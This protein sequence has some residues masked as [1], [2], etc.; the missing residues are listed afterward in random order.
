MFG[1]IPERD[2]YMPVSISDSL[3]L[4]WESSANGSFPASSVSIYDQFVFVNDLSGR[5]HCF[6]IEDGKQVGV[7]KFKGAVYSTPIPFQRIVVF[8]VAL[9]KENLTELVFY[10]F[11]DG[12]EIDV[13]EIPGRVLTEMIALDDAIILTTEMGAVIKYSSR[14]K[15]LWETQTLV[16]TRSSPALKNDMVFFGNDDGE[17]IVLDAES[18][19]SIYV[20]EIGGHFFSGITINEDILYAGNDN[21]N[22]YALDISDGSIIWE[23]DSG[24]RILMTPAVD[25]ENV[26]FGN[27]EGKFFSLNKIDGTANW[28]TQFGGVLNSTPL[29]TDN[30]IVLPDVF[31]SFHLV[32][33]S[34]GRTVKSFVLDGRAKHSPVYFKDVLFIGYDNGNLRAYDFIF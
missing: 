23:Y 11:E 3:A 19:D 5:I 8:P 22:L 30:L 10:N 18:G 16:T 29:L 21:G 17:I 32:N 15:K 24:A 25:E 34:D 33:K 13:I 1:R 27:L 6:N 4:R 9:V 14:G 7:L 28:I 26:I 12:K 2:F 20:A 31:L